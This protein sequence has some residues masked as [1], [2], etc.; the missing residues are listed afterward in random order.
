M[1]LANSSVNKQAVQL[2]DL[3]SEHRV[4]EVGFGGGVGLAELSRRVAFVAGVAPSGPV[5]RAACKRFREEI[6]IGRMQIREAAVDAIP[7]EEGSFDRAL[8]VNT[9]Y[10]WPDPEAGLRE[11]RRL[12]KPDGRLVLATETR[13]VPSRITKHG[14]TPYSEEEQRGLLQSSGFSDIRFERRNAFLFALGTSV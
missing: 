7:F 11:I 1:N 4:L 3:S 10:F 14:F 6:A 13:R 2:L 8:S 12:L 5:V 9:I